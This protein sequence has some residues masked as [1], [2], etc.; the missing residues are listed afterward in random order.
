M[1][2]LNLFHTPIDWDELLDWV[3]RHSGDERPHLVTAAAMGW[4]LAIEL[5]Q[6]SDK[7]NQ[8]D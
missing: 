7:E 1:D 5:H 3:N 8:H 6:Q 4:N 2:K